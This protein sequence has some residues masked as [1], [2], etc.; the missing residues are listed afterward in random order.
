MTKTRAQLEY[1]REQK[2]EHRRKWLTSAQKKEDTPEYLR[3]IEI[4]C[5]KCGHIWVMEEM[6]QVK[7]PSC[8]R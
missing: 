2:M 5:V 7:C 6:E 8:R 4:L 1:E 3:D